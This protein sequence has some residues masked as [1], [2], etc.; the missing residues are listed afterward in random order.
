MA[1]A[2]HREEEQRV[3][4][5]AARQREAQARMAQAQRAQQ[6]GARPPA[7]AGARP[8]SKKKKDKSS[9]DCSLM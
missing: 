2:L 8:G 1:L 5:E 4:A 7:D 3:A 9:S 6:G